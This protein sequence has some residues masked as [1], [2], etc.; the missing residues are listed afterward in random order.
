MSTVVTSIDL[1]V[2]CGAGAH[3]LNQ[4]TQFEDFPKFMSGVTEVHHDRHLHWKAEIGGGKK[5]GMLKSL[6][7]SR[8]SASSGNVT[9]PG[10]HRV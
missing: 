2:R 7:R 10:E 3:C 9:G 6:S 8:I 5:S 1:N 4:W